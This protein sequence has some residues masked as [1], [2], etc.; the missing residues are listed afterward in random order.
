MSHKT[1]CSLGRGVAG[2]HPEP[3]PAPL[4]QPAALSPD[5]A[6]QL[7]GRSEAQL[8]RAALLCQQ[9]EQMHR[10]TSFGFMANKKEIFY[11]L[12]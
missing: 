1:I 10:K 6:R 2:A 4:P 12:Y 3:G 11:K 7:L 5:L 8:T 9:M